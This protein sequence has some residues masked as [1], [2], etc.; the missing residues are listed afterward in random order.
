M[1]DAHSY[2]NLTYL[3]TAHTEEHTKKFYDNCEMYNKIIEVY[4]M[5][6]L[7]TPSTN[8]PGFELNRLKYYEYWFIY[9]L[10]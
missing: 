10:E 7:Q 1:W 9:Y 8:P 6:G 4:D 5:A 3:F 2:L